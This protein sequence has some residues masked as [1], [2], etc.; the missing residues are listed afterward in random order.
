V[1]AAGNNAKVT[2]DRNTGLAPQEIAQAAS[3]LDE[4]HVS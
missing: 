2:I 3:S 4:L 1:Q